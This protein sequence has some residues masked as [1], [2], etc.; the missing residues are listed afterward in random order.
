MLRT[1]ALSLALI[2]SQV[3]AQTNFDDD[4]VKP[5]EP[6][7]EEQVEPVKPYNPYQPRFDPMFEAEPE[8][9]PTCV[10]RDCPN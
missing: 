7:E 5:I 6:E 1:L 8:L 10:G 2:A 4:Y 3:Y 9:E